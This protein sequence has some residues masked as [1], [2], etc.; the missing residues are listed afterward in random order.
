[1]DAR[2]RRLKTRVR[3]GI[4]AGWR[5]PAK[6]W[7]ARLSG[8]LEAEMRWL[9]SLVRRGERVVDVGG[10]Y[11]AYAYALDRLG[12]AVDVFE[13]HP[14]CLD[15]LTAWA[16]PRPTI[17]VHPF[18]L[19]S[20]SGTAHLAIPIEADGVEHDAAA[21]IEPVAP[22]PIRIET[23][24][25][26][27]LDSFGIADAA[28]LKIDVEGHEA[29]VIE[30]ALITI[31]AS[32]P[33]ILIEIEQRHRARPV[34]ETI[35]RIR[36]LGYRGY[37]LDQGGLVDVDRFRVEEHQSLAV[38]GRRGTYHNNFL[39]LSRHRLAAGQYQALGAA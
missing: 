16:A 13:P 29:Q 36:R 26:R 15:A 23:V 34:V 18:A 8:T 21:S 14:A 33:A 7:H 9:P 20:G 6:Y 24:E 38:L 39:F 1:M 3:D 5:V 37:F 31:A 10:N 22:G 32:A 2:I 35:E 12:A 17:R 11:G 30:G 4:P 19:S 28:F 25:M 27:T